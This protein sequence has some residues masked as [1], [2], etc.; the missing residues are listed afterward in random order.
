MEN[1]LYHHGIKGQKW[2]VR[3]FESASGHLTSAGKKRYADEKA[4][5]KSAKKELKV[6]RKELKKAPILAGRSNMD[7]TK[8]LRDNYDKAEMNMIDAKAKY[9]GAKSRNSAKAEFNT[10]RKE[11]Q[12]SGLSGSVADSNSGGRSTKMYDH[13]VAKKGKAYADKVEKKVQNVAVTEFAVGTAV[14]VGSTFVQAYLE[15]K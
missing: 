3:R 10:Y 8:K 15:S 9:N 4:A 14:L 2:G 6:A 11:M 1:E 5:Y 7:K 13:L 12:K